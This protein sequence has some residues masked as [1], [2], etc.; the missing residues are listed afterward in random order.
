MDPSSTSAQ[1]TGEKLVNFEVKEYSNPYFSN[2]F[3]K[4]I[5][6]HTISADMD[7]LRPKEK[8][9]YKCLVLLHFEGRNSYFDRY[10]ESFV[11][12]HAGIHGRGDIVMYL[13]KLSDKNWLKYNTKNKTFEILEPFASLQLDPTKDTVFKFCFNLKL[14]KQ[15]P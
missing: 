1:E 11:E 2:V 6:V 4:L 8:L 10:V 12:E 15:T 7:Y 14:L 13:G 3:E 5:S 9:F